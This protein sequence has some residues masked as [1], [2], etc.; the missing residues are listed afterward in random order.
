MVLAG[1]PALMLMPLAELDGAMV[2]VEPSAFRRRPLAVSE[3]VKLSMLMFAPRTVAVGARVGDVAEIVTAARGPGIN[4]CPVPLPTADVA[5]L[6]LPPATPVD[7]AHT[8]V[9]PV[10]SRQ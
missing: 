2:S 5:Q 8:L 10:R 9:A 6:L 3:M 1:T 7:A 4:G